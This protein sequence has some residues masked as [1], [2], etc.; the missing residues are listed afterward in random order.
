LKNFNKFL[1]GGAFIEIDLPA[2][3]HDLIKRK[4]DITRLFQPQPTL[5]TLNQLLTDPN[6]DIR[7]CT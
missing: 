7:G 2:A 6:V 3:N 5:D 4:S 1:K